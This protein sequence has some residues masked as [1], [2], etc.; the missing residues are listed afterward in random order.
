MKK[1]LTGLATGGLLLSMT[2]G[3][4]FASDDLGGLDM[5][6]Y[7]SHLGLS[8]DAHVKPG[9]QAWYCTATSNDEKDHIKIGEACEWTYKGSKHFASV[10]KEAV[11]GDPYTYNCYF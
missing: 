10:S 7:C 5:N 3:L 9:T 11:P 6:A 2:A 8:S 4:A 1:L